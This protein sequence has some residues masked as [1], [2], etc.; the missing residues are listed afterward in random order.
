MQDPS[1]FLSAATSTTWH[2]NL[3]NSGGSSIGKL[4][5]EFDPSEAIPEATLESFVL[6]KYIDLVEG[7]ASIDLV[8]ADGTVLASKTLVDEIPSVEIISADLSN[9]RQGAS[10]DL[11]WSIIDNSGAETL[12]TV[13]IGSDPDE[14]VVYGDG[15]EL[16][17]SSVT[18]TGIPNKPK[19]KHVQVIV[20]NGS[21][22][23]KSEIFD[24]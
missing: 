19:I 7:L 4:H 18:L 14:M 17:G 23:A 2:L 5:F 16:E 20:T 15:F 8:D 9:S 24:L 1:E 10:I 12:T 3:K 13:L 6:A 21:R 11:A 22:S